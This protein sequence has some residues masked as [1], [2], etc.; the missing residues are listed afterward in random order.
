MDKIDTFA[1]NAVIICAVACLLVLTVFLG[2]LIV[3]YIKNN[4]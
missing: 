3:R 1:L 4:P 2:V